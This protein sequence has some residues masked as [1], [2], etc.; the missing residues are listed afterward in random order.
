[1][2]KISMT[3][4]C[5]LWYRTYEE[6]SSQER[7]YRP[8]GYPLPPTRGREI[9]DLRD[10]RSARQTKPGPDDRPTSTRGSW[11]IDGDVLAFLG[12]AKLGNESANWKVSLLT[13]DEMVLS[14]IGQR[15]EL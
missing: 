6:G 14:D 1:M 3:H 11:S 4:L 12:D 2:T 15:E 7:H 9:L 13:E 8:D 10:L 5:R